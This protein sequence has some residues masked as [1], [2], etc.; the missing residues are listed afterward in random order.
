MNVAGIVHEIHARVDEGFGSPAGDMAG[1]KDDALRSIRSSVVEPREHPAGGR[2]RLEGAIRFNPE[3]ISALRSG[4]LKASAV[5][6]VKLFFGGLIFQVF[7][8]GEMSKG[9]EGLKF[10]MESVSHGCM[11]SIILACPRIVDRGRKWTRS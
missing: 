11:L 4:D 7:D 1:E 10:G 8:E 5:S 2:S 6:F 9:V 3:L